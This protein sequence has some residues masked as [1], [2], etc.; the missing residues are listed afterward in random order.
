[1]T[2]PTWSSHAANP[3]ITPRDEFNREGPPEAPMLI[4]S[5][6]A[7]EIL[8]T[9]NPAKIKVS[10]MAAFDGTSCPEEHMMAYKNLMLLYTT[11]PALLCNFFPTTLTCMA[12]TWYTSLPVGSI[13]TFTQ[14]EAKVLGHFVASRRQEK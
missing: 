10:N 13:N 4:N 14:L 2:Q 3:I 9:P 1:M 8:A 7:A 12:L 11:D 6:L 5:P